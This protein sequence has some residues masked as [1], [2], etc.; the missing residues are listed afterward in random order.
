MIENARG[1]GQDDV[2]EPTRGKEQID[3]RLDLGDLDVE[4]RRNDTSLVKTTVKLYDDL[5]GTM[6]VD[7]LKLSNVSMTLHDTQEFDNDFGA[8]TDKDLTFATTLRV[9]N[10]VKAVIQY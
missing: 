8:G 4:A 7:K 2:S 9:D 6:V 1:S 5:A 10:A 3:P